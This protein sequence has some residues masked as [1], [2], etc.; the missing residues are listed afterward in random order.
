MER[1]Y[2]VRYE[3]LLAECEVG[4]ALLRGSLGRLRS[5][6]H[7]FLL[8]LQ[9]PQQSV[10]ARTY[11]RGLLSNLER[12]NV[13]SIAY[14]DDQGRRNLQHFIGTSEWDH[15]PLQEEL[16]RQV[17]QQLG[18]EDGV[19]VI[20]PS[21]FAKKGNRS[22]GV[23]RQ[24]C[25]RHGKVENCQ[26]AVY[27]GY[28]SRQE[29]ALVDV[30]LY[31]PREWTNSRKRCAEAGVPREIRFQT[32]H[33][34]ALEMIRRNGAQLPHA[35]ITADDEFG[36]AATFRRDLHEL[37]ERYVL[38]VPSNTNV[39][40]L[41][42]E[43]PA[44]DPRA[45][46]KTPFCRVDRWAAAQP[47]SKW[48]SVSVRD[49]EKGPL[50][51]EV[52]SCRV[53]AKLTATHMPYDELLVVVRCLDECGVTKIDYYLSNA[54]PATA[55]R[56][57]ARVA[58]AEHRIEECIK[59]GKSDAGLAD[60][61][62]QK[63]AGWHHHQV[64]SLIAA[65]FLIEETRRGKKNHAGADGAASSPSAVEPAVHGIAMRHAR[66]DRAPDTASTATQRASTLLSSQKT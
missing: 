14:R 5:F 35:W 9:L 24:W 10:H 39:R 16:I 45:H 17:G 23:A 41:E 52:I 12:K 54:S 46:R 6:V 34:L 19:V 53:R 2:Q 3:E 59:R 47:N 64:L 60:Y 21:A 40:D 36:R 22:V 7:P 62:V 48:T 8:C 37:G 51:V 65:W 25:G 11:V 61:E 56:E 28:V 58:K 57:L 42:I 30:R 27:L 26:L 31:L 50:E 32:R 49:G 66:T 44:A 33:E 63:W 43:P 4:P 18:E 55:R 1:R 13:E 29:H 20:D 15:R 38:A